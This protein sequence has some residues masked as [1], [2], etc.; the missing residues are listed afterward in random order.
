LKGKIAFV[1]DAG[2]PTY[3]LRLFVFSG[4]D[5]EGEGDDRADMELPGNQ[6]ALLIDTLN[7]GMYENHADLA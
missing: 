2:R 1:S 7:S 6:S 4:S 3:R 5:I